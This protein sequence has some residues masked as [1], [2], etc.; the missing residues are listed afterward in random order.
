MTGPQVTHLQAL[1]AEAGEDFDASLDRAGADGR[2]AEL[3]RRLP[4]RGQD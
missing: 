2:I 1:S 4:G 3:E